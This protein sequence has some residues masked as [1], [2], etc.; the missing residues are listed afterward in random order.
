MKTASANIIGDKL[1]SDDCVDG[2]L[3][4]IEQFVVFTKANI[5]SNRTEGIT[6]C[7]YETDK[8]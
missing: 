4:L 6:F 8:N 5:I 3:S 2:K 1:L 7:H